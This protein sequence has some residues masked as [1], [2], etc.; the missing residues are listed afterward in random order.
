VAGFEPEIGAVGEGFGGGKE[1][2]VA[3]GCMDA[4]ARFGL[5]L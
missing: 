1:Q 4:E 3:V 5:R 2:A